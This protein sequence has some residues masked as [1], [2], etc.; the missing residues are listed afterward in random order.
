LPKNTGKT[1]KKGGRGGKVCGWK[2]IMNATAFLQEDGEPSPV[3][4][5]H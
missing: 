4:A 3:R 2:M 1:D 5:Q